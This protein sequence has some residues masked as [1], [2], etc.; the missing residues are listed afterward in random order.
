MV[1]VGIDGESGPRGEYERLGDLLADLAEVHGPVTDE[2]LVAA[3]AEWL[4][5]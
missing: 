5:R 3:R 1:C 2:E 4:H